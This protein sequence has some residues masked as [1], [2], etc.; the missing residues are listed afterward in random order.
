MLVDYYSFVEHLATL[1]WN[2]DVVFRPSKHLYIL[3]WACIIPTY[4]YSACWTHAHVR[5]P[6]SHTLIPWARQLGT[7]DKPT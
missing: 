2:A 6:L 4:K 5:R 7:N 1:S 3:N